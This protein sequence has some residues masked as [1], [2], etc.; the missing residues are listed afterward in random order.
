MISKIKESV[1]NGGTLGALMT[2]RIKILTVCII[3]AK[4][5]AYN[6]DLKS[7]RLTQIENRGL[8]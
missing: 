1:D 2:D 5:D 8:K 7:I 4:S 6:F 3:K